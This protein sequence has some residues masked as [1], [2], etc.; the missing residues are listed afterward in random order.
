MSSFFSLNNIHHS[1]KSA[2]LSFCSILFCFLSPF[3]F[4]G[5]YKIGVL[6]YRGESNAMQAW[7]ATGEY[8]TRSLPSHQFTIVPLNIPEMK[9]AIA[10]AEVDFVITQATQYVSM[11]VQ[12]GISRIATI[13]RDYQGEDYVR[14]GSVILARSDRNDINELLDLGKKVFGAVDNSALGGWQMANGEFDREN[15]SLSKINYY[16]FPQSNVVFAIRDGL[17]DAGSV[18]ARIY[19]DLVDKGVIS[20][21][22]F[23]IISAR[24]TRGYPF[25]HS[26][27]LYPEW[28]IAKLSHMSKVV[29]EQVVNAL[30]TLDKE[31]KATKAANISGW[32]VPL[33]YRPIHALMQQ[34]NIPPFDSQIEPR[35]VYDVK[36]EDNK[37]YLLLTS[38]LVLSMLLLIWNNQK[39]RRGLVGKLTNKNGD[40]YLPDEMDESV[41]L[42]LSNIAS[43]V[44][45]LNKQGE[46]SYLNQAA[47]RMLEVEDNDAFGKTPAELIA[48]ESHHIDL[49]NTLL[50]SNDELTDAK[51]H[52][53]ITGT[54]TSKNGKHYSIELSTKLLQNKSG[55]WVGSMLVLQDN[56]D[57]NNLQR[58]IIYQSSHDLLTGLIN[59]RQFEMTLAESMTDV[60][61]KGLDSALLY[62]D[63]DQFRLV[64]DSCGHKAGDELLKMIADKI[65]QLT[66]TGEWIARI[67]ADEFAVLLNDCSLENAYQIAERIRKSI[68]QFRFVWQDKMFEISVSIGVVAITQQYGSVV[69][70]LNS[71]DIACFAAKDSGRNKT[72]VYSEKD[73]VITQRRGEIQWAQEIQFALDSNSFNLVCQPILATKQQS[74]STNYVEVLVRMKDSKGREILPMAFIPAAERYHLMTAVDRWV[75]QN[76]AKALKAAD[77]TH[78]KYICCFI[79]ISSQTISDRAFLTFVLDV[80]KENDLEPSCLCFEITEASTIEN[81]KQ[82]SHLIK[83]LQNIGCKFAIDN[84]GTGLSSFTF[85]KELPVNF[86]K[87]DGSFIRSMEKDPVARAI[88]DSINKISHTMDIEAIAEYVENEATLEDVRSFNLDYIQGNFVSK[89]KKLSLVLDNIRREVSVVDLRLN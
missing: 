22:Q 49:K 8:L 83:I 71:A 26:T 29:S 85:L 72:H 14:Y 41:Q 59:R 70:L 17:V 32:T 9:Q 36:L 40:D 50:S 61:T 63:L 38:L 89:P 58:K 60:K 57:A 81:Y 35:I 24:T 46:I 23:K 48:F 78:S 3:S 62:I 56:T 79:N 12:Y 54:F 33:D 75:V 44:L 18:R 34:L 65:T 87:I 53:K 80:I 67:S 30:L 76:T 20:F 28:P 19:Y 13:K 7:S 77:L 21:D 5:D 2:K 66:K 84:F 1:T 37:Y 4:A 45:I 73:K 39:L 68:E 16:G 11:E 69:E 86:I 15:I 64:N 51:S 10:E 27:D 88:V 55:D 31:H 47:K 6:A 52:P 82:A 42:A 43:A 74:A 25:L